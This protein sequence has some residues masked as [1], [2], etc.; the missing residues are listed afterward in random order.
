MR[1]SGDEQP[2]GLAVPLLRGGVCE[3]RADAVSIGSKVYRTT[4]I[5]RAR[6]VTDPTILVPPNAPPWPAV[7]LTLRDGRRV[8]LTPADPLDAWRLLEVLFTYAPVLWIGLPPMPGRGEWRGGV[9]SVPGASLGGGVFGGA[10]FGAP[11][12]AAPG[13]NEAVLAGIAHLSLFFAPIVLPL[14]IW[15]AA[16][17]RSLYAARQARQAFFF[18]LSYAA[19]VFLLFIGWLVVL[20]VVTGHARPSRAGGSGATFAITFAVLVA[21]LVALA[22]FESAWGIYGAIQGF[23]GRPFSYPL[24]SR[25]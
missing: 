2:A 17:E 23:R 4:E 25:L 15:L 1:G 9:S 7:E 18:H 10:I 8:T 6:L 16:G 19:M 5:G 13:S 12:S 11:D 24:M 3:L 22:I 14:I 20:F 21:L